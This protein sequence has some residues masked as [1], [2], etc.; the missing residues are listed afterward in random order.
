MDRAQQPGHVGWF[1]REPGVLVLLL[2]ATLTVMANA[3]I[4]PALTGLAAYYSSVVQADLL[5][6]LLVPAPSIAVL[7]LATLAGLAADRYGR[8]RQLLLG[9]GLFALAGSMGLFIDDLHLLLASRIALGVAVSIV[10][11]A[12]SALNRDYFNAK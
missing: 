3:T 6:R 12:Q 11:T 10:V 8:R 4:S 1:I 7:F 5:I 9:V 2:T